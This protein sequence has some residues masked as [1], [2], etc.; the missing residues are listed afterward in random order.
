[1]V[2]CEWWMLKWC[3][4]EHGVGMNWDDYDDYWDDDGDRRE[5]G[6]PLGG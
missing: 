1:M 6:G 5:F 3:N 4:M 2:K